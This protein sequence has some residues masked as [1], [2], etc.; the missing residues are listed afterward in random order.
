[1]SLE[2]LVGPE[3]SRTAHEYVRDTLRAAVLDGTLRVGV[4][5]VQSELAERLGVSTTPVREALRNLASEGLVVFDPHRGALVRSLDMA[6]VRELY[7]LRMTLEPIMIRRVIDA[8]TPEQLAAAAELQRR[9]DQPCSS[10][11]WAEVNREFHALFSAADGSSRLAGLLD[12]LRDSSAPYVARS[13][14]ARPEQIKEA[15]AEHAALL[16]M[17]Q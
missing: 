8:V 7:E 5:L 10:S 1:M 16:G 12:G 6:E 9:M 11:T 2:K 13:L 3:R 4:R 15:N 17:Y 14:I